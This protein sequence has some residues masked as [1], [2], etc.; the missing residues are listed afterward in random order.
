MVLALRGYLIDLVAIKTCGLLP[1]K[2]IK[3]KLY[4]DI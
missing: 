4:F 3:C 2:G 1:E